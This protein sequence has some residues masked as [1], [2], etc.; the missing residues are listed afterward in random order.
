[1]VL[2]VPKLVWASSLLVHKKFTGLYVGD[3]GEPSVL[4]SGQGLYLV[5]N[6]HPGIHFFGK[7][8]CDDIKPHVFGSDEF[9]VTRRGYKIP[10]LLFGGFDLLVD[11]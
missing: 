7:T 6:H 10:Y 5:F 3:F 1:M 4:L 11:L 9:E 8:G 2:V